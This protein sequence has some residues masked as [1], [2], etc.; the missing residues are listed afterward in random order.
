MKGK[1]MGRLLQITSTIRERELAALA[2]V[3]AQRQT[4]L[5]KERSLAQAMREARQAGQ[6]GVSDAHQAEAFARWVD[7][8]TH[9]INEKLAQLAPLIDAQRQ[10]TAAAVGRHETLG[11]LDQRLKKD[12]KQDKA[13]RQSQ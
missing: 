10:R 6:G 3:M 1:G 12:Q 11:E 4:L 2:G 8:Q 9:E 13:R 7:Q 5:D